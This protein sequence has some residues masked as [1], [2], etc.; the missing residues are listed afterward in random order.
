MPIRV[1]EEVNGM[2]TA[3]LK[4]RLDA[5][6]QRLRPRREKP[7]IVFVARVVP[8]GVEEPPI[9]GGHVRIYLGGENF[10][11]VPEAEIDA[12]LA[13][14]VDKNALVILPPVLPLD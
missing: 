13:E 10:A 3:R 12:W 1:A 11:D 7:G 9:P 6:E 4:K 8:W 14:H 2:S 5:V